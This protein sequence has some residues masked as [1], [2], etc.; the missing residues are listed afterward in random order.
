VIYLAFIRFENVS[1][2][3]SKEKPLIKDLNLELYGNSFT[4]IMGLNGSGK[5]TLGKL[6]IGMVRPTRG[7]VF[8]EEKEITSLSLGEIGSTIGYL[9]QNPEFQIFA[10][11][12]FDELSFVL[13]LKD[14]NE[15]QIN[16]DVKEVLNLLHLSDKK[17]SVT[18]NLSYGEKQRLAM[19]GILLN[20]PKY[21][22]LDEPTTGLDIVRKEVLLSILKQL[23][24][25]GIGM[26]VISHDE[27]FIRNF[28]GR[29]LK[30]K[31]GIVY[32]TSIK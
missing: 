11:N 29:L 12:V 8:I 21:L 7:R 26:S 27:K 19:A 3:Y 5:T 31:D 10:T 18:F 23:L 14:I 2:Q 22:L 4:A 28:T 1:F 13:K 32:E 15:D 16:Q 9:F 6:L 17:D 20:R 24:D 30:M 25:R